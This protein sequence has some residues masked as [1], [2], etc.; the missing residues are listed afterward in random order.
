MWIEWFIRCSTSMNKW[1]LK[2][3]CNE[4]KRHRYI[5]SFSP[6][7]FINNHKIDQISLKKF[8]WK[9]TEDERWKYSKKKSRIPSTL[10]ASSVIGALTAAATVF[11]WENDGV[12][13]RELQE[14]CSDDY[15]LNMTNSQV[16]DVLTSLGWEKL[17]RKDHLM[18]F[19]K[20]D[21]EL[22]VYSYKIFGTF[23][24]I[25]ALVFF[26][27]QLDLDYRMNWDDHALRLSVV[28]ANESTQSDIVHW[29]QKFPFPFNHRDY[30]YVRRYC[31]DTST[32]IPPKI[33]IKCHSI[34]HP[35][36]HDDKKCVRVNKYESSM[37]IQSKT[38][39]DEKGIKFLLT[40]HED[41]KASMPTSTYS[42]LAQSGIPNFV[43]KLHIA[44]KQ[45]PKS[46]QFLSIDS[47]PQCRFFDDI[48]N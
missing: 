25:S 3:L 39:L 40:Y 11:S 6:L 2:M 44:A 26:Q 18:L 20:Y 21:D 46:K 45:L 47:L 30:L 34:N 24:D 31:F 36:V 1:P 10:F 9:K 7:L 42:Y 8:D 32:N 14:A 4:C 5:F 41:A 17:L 29:I 12:S 37:I 22:Q 13:D 23:N 33:V 16:N 27:V 43:E 15:L 19:R 35:N 48:S 38:K 28:D